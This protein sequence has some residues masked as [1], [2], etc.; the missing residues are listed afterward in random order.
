[1]AR[2]WTV[3]FFADARGTRPVAEFITALR[4]NPKLAAKVLRSIDLL[5]QFGVDLP[6]PHSAPLVGY[7]F[8]ELRVRHGSDIARLFYA[9]MP[10]RRIV[11]LHGFQK[12]RQ[13]T[14]RREL[15]IAQRRL[16]ALKETNRRG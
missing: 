5:Q 4:S 1:M 3:E 7:E 9:A 2:V 8:R 13:A 12:K 6:M 15:E 14:P 16:Q 11:L 10:G